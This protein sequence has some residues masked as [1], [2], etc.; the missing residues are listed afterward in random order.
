MLSVTI[1]MLD[2]PRTYIR[3][4]KYEILGL[5]NLSINHVDTKETYQVHFTFTT[6]QVLPGSLGSSDKSIL[7]LVSL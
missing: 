5:L 2:Y 6:G 3:S 1:N 7:N 4:D